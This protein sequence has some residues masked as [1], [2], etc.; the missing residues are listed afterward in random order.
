MNKIYLVQAAA[1]MYDDYMIWPV[2]AFAKKE[3]ADKYIS[4]T[5]C[6][7]DKL[8]DNEYQKLISE[9]S[10][11]IKKPV[12]DYD[13]EGWDRYEEMINKVEQKAFEDISAKY[14][15]YDLN[16]TDDFHGYHIVEVEYTE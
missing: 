1:G 4:V 9:L 11:D 6:K 2:Q 7:Y 5:P 10:I 14:P 13:S 15:D 12:D 3:D 16:T 8:I